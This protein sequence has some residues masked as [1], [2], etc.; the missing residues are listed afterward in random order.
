MLGFSNVTEYPQGWQNYLNVLFY[1]AER[2]VSQV[3]LNLILTKFKRDNRNSKYLPYRKK[4]L[5]TF[6]MKNY[7]HIFT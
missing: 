3:L 2:C 7:H 4:C 1:F 5:Q 6:R